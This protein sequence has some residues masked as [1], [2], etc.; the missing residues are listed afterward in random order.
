MVDFSKHL[1][2]NL[3]KGPVLKGK[4]FAWDVETDGLDPHHGARIFCWSYYTEE[5]EYGFMLKTPENLKWL[6]YQLKTKRVVG[7][8][9]KFD[10]TMMKFEGFD[11][12]E[13]NPLRIH[14]TLILAKL[15]NEQLLSYKLKYLAVRHLGRSTDDKDEV[16]EWLKKNKR[17]FIKEHGRPPNF[18][19]APIEV[20]KRRAIWDTCSTLMLFMHLHPQIKKICHTLYKT[21]QE[22]TF[23]CIDM[24]TYGVRVDITRAKE[25]RE[26]AY[27]DLERI[28]QD[29]DDLIC[30]L[31]VRKSRKDKN[32]DI[33]YEKLIFNEFN[34]GSTK[35]HLPAA[36]EKLGIKL[37][38]RTKPQKKKGGG[39]T[40]GGNWSFDEYAM[41]RYA[42]KKLVPIMRKSSEEGW[43]A[44]KFYREIHKA[45][46]KYK[47]D[48]K[49]LLPPLIMKYRQV[50]KMISTYY[51]NFINM[52]VDI[53]VAPNGRE[54]GIL[55]CQFNQSEA[56]TGRFS[57]S[58]PN[59]QNLPRS[60]GPRECFVPRMGR[61]NWHIDYDQVEIKFFVHFAQDEGMRE[62]T[63]GD[64]HRYTATKVYKKPADKITKEQRSRA[65]GTNFGIIYGSGAE[66]Q[67]ETLTKDGL[68]TTRNEMVE[69]LAAYHKEFPAV[70]RLMGDLERQL[71]RDGYVANSFG[72]RYHVPVKLAWVMLNYMCQ[73][74][75]ADQV[76]EAMVACWKWLR[77]HGYK[78][79]IIKTIH[80]EIVFEV[81]QAE[82][83]IVIP[84]LMEIMEDHESFF[85]PITVSADV[86]KKTWAKKKD[87]IKDLGYTWAKNDLREMAL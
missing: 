60:L 38:Y 80:D 33:L 23:V 79:R 67:A 55:H 12:F 1:K 62:A 14:D 10:L 4:I 73:G 3:P 9:I 24:E 70:R 42:S 51:D 81:P 29:L 59:L 8:N 84:K 52:S 27:Q 5:G 72:R 53:K 57:S 22:L 15:E 37:V 35:I 46:K 25:L 32:G 48:K 50:S 61:K 86:V 75:S 30:P 64:F 39:K 76:K 2:K 77:K 11:I 43:N 18:S 7:H 36:F 87:A 40:K 85:V 78:T 58:K 13:L 71:R 21:E 44:A 82:E 83:K 20:V 45:A 31:H 34:P 26:T 17:I 6:W 69:F 74:T 28:K 66:T 65:K 16:E 49:E 63:S 41:M 68:P 54:Y 56:K 47:L 19:D